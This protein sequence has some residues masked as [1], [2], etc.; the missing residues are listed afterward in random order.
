MVMEQ[1]H[2]PGAT[3]RW[4][5]RRVDLLCLPSTAAQQRLGGL[6]V[7]TGNPVRQAFTEIGPAAQGAEPSILVF[8]GSRGAHSINVAMTDALRELARLDPLP[9]IVHQT[10]P[11]DEEFVRAAYSDY[12]GRSEVHAFLHDMPVRL[13]AAELVV[14]RAGAST[15]SELAAAGR[16]AILAPYPHA[17]DDHQR[18]NAE[19]VREAGAAWLLTDAE[20]DGA[21]L[22]QMIGEACARR[23]LLAQMGL[24]ARTLARPDAAAAIATLAQGLIG[25]HRVP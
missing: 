1:N 6:G 13:A 20:L 17:A 24:A 21:R 14:C 19:S 22:A 7:V 5:A 3:N 10:G 2:F 16:P 8:G 25:G 18:H 4:L 9:R 11:A 12:P 15:L 23:D